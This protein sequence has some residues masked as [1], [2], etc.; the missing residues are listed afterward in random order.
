MII[1]RVLFGVTEDNSFSHDP[2]IKDM[3]SYKEAIIDIS[4]ESVEEYHTTLQKS[5]TNLNNLKLKSSNF[6]LFRKIK[7]EF[8][9]LK[10][11][12][13]SIGRWFMVARILVAVCIFI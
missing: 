11:C 4:R 12:P 3:E 13:A 7:G 8:Q 6:S 10:I 9:L 1:E 5:M 2:E